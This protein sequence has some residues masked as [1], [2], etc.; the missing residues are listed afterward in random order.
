MGS[1]TAATFF[2]VAEGWR[3]VL[4]QNVILS[5]VS[6]SRGTG[7]LRISGH[8]DSLPS[9]SN[10]IFN[11]QN[12]AGQVYSYR[13]YT[14]RINLV[15]QY[16]S[17]ITAVYGSTNSSGTILYNTG[18]TVGFV[19]CVT[20]SGDNSAGLYN[21]FYIRAEEGT[22]FS[23]QLGSPAVYEGSYCNPPYIRSIDTMPNEPFRLS[24]DT[25][26]LLH[27]LKA[28]SWIR[29]YCFYPASLTQYTSIVDFES[30]AEFYV[31]KTGGNSRFERFKV[32]FEAKKI[33]SSGVSCYK[34]NIETFEKL[35]FTKYRLAKDPN[36]H[37]AAYLEFYFNNSNNGSDGCYLSMI[38]NS[39][40]YMISDTNRGGY[41]APYIC[42]LD[43][44]GN[45]DTIIGSEVT[46]P[47]A[48]GYVNVTF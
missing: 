28:K 32:A 12:Y 30:C 17:N 35:H 45:N 46:L 25:R 26:I 34:I 43:E 39:E 33:A 37:G 5:N 42:G 13:N 22:D 7:W 41:H 23:V 15:P 11:C 4:N 1:A 27:S 31:T 38:Y 47:A 29:V 19:N 14:Y 6:I 2:I 40:G 10:Y 18:N 21:G 36:N 44:L 20:Y 3:L 16:T 24:D 48:S 9:N 8:V